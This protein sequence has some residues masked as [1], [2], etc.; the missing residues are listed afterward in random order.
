MYSRAGRLHGA[1]WRSPMPWCVHNARAAASS[2]GLMLRSRPSAL[3]PVR[4]PSTSSTSAMWSAVTA[5][6]I[7]WWPG[8]MAGNGLSCF[9]ETICGSRLPRP[10]QRRTL[11]RSISSRAARGRL[12]VDVDRR[13]SS[14][15]VAGVSP[16]EGVG[17]DADAART[18]GEASPLR[19]RPSIFNDNRFT[20]NTAILAQGDEQPS[21]CYKALY[22]H[23]AQNPD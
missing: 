10:R 9:R 2:I 8:P 3:G 21:F 12:S 20:R 22:G 15:G 16:A 17:R 5:R 4:R 19:L 13:P 11:C 7:S 23:L 18:Q 14:G 6:P 1:C